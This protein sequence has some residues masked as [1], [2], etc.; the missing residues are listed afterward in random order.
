MKRGLGAKSK[1]EK[2]DVKTTR[3]N[4]RTTSYNWRIRKNWRPTTKLKTRINSGCT[5]YSMWRMSRGWSPTVFENRRWLEWWWSGK[6][7]LMVP[8]LLVVG[9]GSRSSLFS[10]SMSICTDLSLL[11]GFGTWDGDHVCRSGMQ[12]GCLR[13]DWFWQAHVGSYRTSWVVITGVY[14]VVIPSPDQILMVWRS[15]FSSCSKHGQSEPQRPQ[16][17]GRLC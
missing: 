14:Y 12:D 13:G 3:R 6:W 15:W 11:L 16:I 5:I 7:Q 17:F 10:G 4:W 2:S 1:C 8:L 9:V